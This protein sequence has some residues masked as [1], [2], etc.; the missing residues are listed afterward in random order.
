MS[1]PYNR[2]LPEE[3]EVPLDPAE[4]WHSLKDFFQTQVQAQLRLLLQDDL[5]QKLGCHDL[6]EALLV[7]RERLRFYQQA[8]DEMESLERRLR[9]GRPEQRQPYSRR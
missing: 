2:L 6:H 7:A 4:L 5:A 3:A 8:H 9:D 1:V